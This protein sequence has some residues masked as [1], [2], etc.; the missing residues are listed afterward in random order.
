[1]LGVKDICI[2]VPDPID[3]YVGGDKTGIT[4]VDA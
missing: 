3:G 1:M 4:T 2:A